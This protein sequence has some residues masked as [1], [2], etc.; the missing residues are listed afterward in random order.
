MEMSANTAPDHP[1][2]SLLTRT[3]FVAVIIAVYGATWLY[4]RGLSFPIYND[5][6]QFWRLTSEFAANWP[7]SIAEIQ[8]YKEP[9]T[10]LSFLV[11]SFFE[12]LFSGGV[13]WVRHINFLASFGMLMLVGLHR[14]SSESTRLAALGLLAYPYFLPMGMHLYTDLPAALFVLLAFRMPKH[15]LARAGYLTL[16]VATRQYMVVFPL[17]LVADEIITALRSKNF[18]PLRKSLPNAVAAA[19]LLGWVF[20]FGG[21][22]PDAGLTEWPRHIDNIGVF[23]PMLGIHFLTTMGIYFVVPEFVLFRRWHFVTEFLT[24][25]SLVIAAVLL[26]FY[27]IDPPIF[28]ELK[29]GITGRA[30]E[31]LPVPLRMIVFFVL[32]WAT[33]IRFARIDLAFWVLVMQLLIVLNAFS[34]WEKYALPVLAVFWFMKATGELDTPEQER[35]TARD[36]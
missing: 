31:V 33:C 25:K 1:L 23:E 19:T 30:A 34:A 27:L 10:P 15:S 3:R 26:L 13:Q 20:F 14:G 7:P 18:A 11:W 2:L 16:A 35:D 8:N 29:Q 36:V 22:G 32:G 28:G 24:K 17:A 4:T 21:L 12:S 6:V 5:E 9:M